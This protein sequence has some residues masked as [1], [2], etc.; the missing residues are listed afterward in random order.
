MGIIFVAGMTLTPINIV[1][2]GLL[3]VIVE[4]SKMGRVS[5]WIDPIMMFGQSATL[6]MI[7]LLYPQIISLGLLYAAMAVL[8]YGV[9]LI[10][11]FTLPEMMGRE[12]Q[13]YSQSI[14][15]SAEQ[16]VHGTV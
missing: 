11:L 7:A 1:L 2:G 16:E 8:L 13:R 6:G 15:E 12:E 3:P 4:P 5:A 9:F 14:K 10:Y